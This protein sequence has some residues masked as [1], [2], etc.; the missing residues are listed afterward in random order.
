MLDLDFK[1]REEE[2]RKLRDFWRAALF[3]SHYMREDEDS[4]TDSA[5]FDDNSL[6]FCFFLRQSDMLYWSCSVLY[7]TTI[8]HFTC[9]F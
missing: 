2:K 9:T 5:T 4:H 7:K 8:L 3:I 1:A 6:D